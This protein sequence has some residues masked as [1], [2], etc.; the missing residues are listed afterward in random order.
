MAQE[1]ISSPPCSRTAM[2][3]ASQLRKPKNALI[4]A[5]WRVLYSDMIFWFISGLQLSVVLPCFPL[6]LL[7]AKPG[8]RNMKDMC[9]IRCLVRCSETLR[10]QSE[11]VRR[12]WLDEA[13]R[14]DSNLR[15]DT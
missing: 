13:S 5:P 2:A 11:G 4:A 6:L 3:M 12:T 9:H 10:V 15:E 8:E 1:H 14:D 7:Q